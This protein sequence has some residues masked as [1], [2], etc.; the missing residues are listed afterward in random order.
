MTADYLFTGLSGDRV[1][2][3]LGTAVTGPCP[4]CGYPTLGSALCAFCPPD[5]RHLRI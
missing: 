2:A 3:D 4:E 1:S 5:G